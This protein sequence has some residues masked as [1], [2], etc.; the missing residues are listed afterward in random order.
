METYDNPFVVAE[1]PAEL[2]ASFYRKTYGLV[3][4]SFVAWAGLLSLIFVSGAWVPLSNLML[5]SQF[6]WLL[7]LAL[8]WGATAV[9]NRLAFSR[10]SAAQQYSGLGIYIVAY[11]LLFTPLIAV[12]IAQTEGNPMQILAP[13]GG[14]TLALIAALTATVFM[15]KTDFSFLKT[16]VVIGSF[17]AMGVI[18]MAIV[19]GISLGTW[20][21]A[22]MIV[23]MAAA[24]LWQTWQVKNQVATDQHVGAAVILFA[25]FMTLLWYVIQLFLS[26][27]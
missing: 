17:C 2:R 15:T 6:G 5:G 18:L 9:G 4:A 19:F 16:A 20:F 24:I 25:G 26:R 1:A 11:A 21:A 3:A 23:L 8:F 22:A 27:R 10:A 13:A 14:V 7:V 12:V